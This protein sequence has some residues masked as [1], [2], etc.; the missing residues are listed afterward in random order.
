MLL[1]PYAFIFV[2]MCIIAIVLTVVTGRIIT[3]LRERNIDASD[4]IIGW[5]LFVLMLQMMCMLVGVVRRPVVCAYCHN[6]KA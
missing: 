1:Q 5:L 2:S 6:K 3:N 4:N